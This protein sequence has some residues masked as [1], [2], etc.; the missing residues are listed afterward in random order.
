MIK[1]IP[2]STDA[3]DIRRFERIG[4]N[5]YRRSNGR[6]Y[7]RVTI[8]GKRKWH[9]LDV[10]ETKSARRLIREW[11]DEEVLKA[12]GIELPG[13][14]LERNRLT[15]G[16]VLDGYVAADC[17]TR[18][19]LPKSPQTVT[20]ELKC[21]NPIRAYF[22]GRPAVAL[23]LGV[24]DEYRTWRNSGGY[25]IERK[26]KDGNTVSVRTRGG[27][28]G[29]DLELTTLSNALGLAVRRGH[30]KSNPLT[31]RTP[32]GVAAEVR[33]CR[34]V[35]PTPQGLTQIE[36]W[37]RGKGEQ[38]VADLVCFLAFTGLRIGEAIP[39]EWENVDMA[40][41][42]L[43]VKR[44]KR[45]IMP[46]VPI[47]LELHGLLLEMQKRAK[48]YLLFPSPFDPE[49]TRDKARI[50]RWLKSAT[51][52]LGLPHVTPH[53]LRSYFVTQARQSGLTDAEIAQLIGDKTGPA[54]IATTYGDVRPDHLFRQ[55]QRIQLRA[56]GKANEPAPKAA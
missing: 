45:G 50:N 3:K 55:A 32:Y 52:A 48:S 42:L 29:V 2:K 26:L 8:S 14:V 38:E 28:R 11:R 9:C 51:E 15:V 5:L 12:R 20:N 34:E 27:N 25:V 36:H 6:L 54:I 17:P 37:L 56:T 35:A 24:C 44:E 46:W 22:E 16:K 39:L 30:L 41:S 21:L 1:Q 33:H 47:L 10:E 7:C 31:G 19:M 18:K 53:G 13:S 43:H 4:D 23:T 49:Q 40:S